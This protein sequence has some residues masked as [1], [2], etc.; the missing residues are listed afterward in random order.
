MGEESAEDFSALL[1]ASLEASET[2]ISTGDR[3]RAEILAVGREEVRVALGP[4]REGVVAT[5]DF[6]DADGRVAVKAGDA[7]DLFVISIRPGEIRLSKNPT[8]KNL[9]EDL[10]EAFERRA[11]IEG[12][13]IEVCKGGFRVS[14]KGKTAF[15]PISQMDTKRTE[16]GAEFVGKTFAF[17]ITEFSEDGRNIVVSRRKLLEEEQ[18]R[19]ANAFLEANPDG[20][21]AT[22]TVVRL[23]KFGAFVELVPG[24]E[25]LA[26]VSELAWSRIESPAEILTVGQS[27]SVKI[28]K[29][30]TVDG[31]LKI[32]LSLKQVTER[33]ARPAAPAV[34][35]PWTKYAAG[36]VLTGK[37]TRKEVYGLF[38]QLEPGVVGLLHQSKTSE[39]SE[40][41][42]AKQK[43]G[44]EIQVQ[45]AEVKLG[46]RRISLELPRDPGEN[47]WKE[48]LQSGDAAPGG[49]GEA[50]RAALEKKKR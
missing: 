50:L 12:R 16:T 13:V 41:H 37:I 2:P 14:V 25:G 40:F 27:L 42:L 17:G 3:A 30:E 8:D 18:G 38:I 49:L 23:E 34:V 36:Q 47:D 9:A 44:E 11:P 24:V 22:G 6:L 10:K 5:A 19:A 45:V 21:V 29:S 32:S 46:E 39:N 26:H 15:C 48:H 7:V 43:V 20:A 31:R 28:L 33:P 4:G 1:G 35:D